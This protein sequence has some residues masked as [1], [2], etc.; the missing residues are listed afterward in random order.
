MFEENIRNGVTCPP[1]CMV[2]ADSNRDLIDSGLLIS[3]M[4]DID[5]LPVKPDDWPPPIMASN[6][7]CGAQACAVS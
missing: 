7:R 6:A 4:A 1:A 2:L 3:R 5:G